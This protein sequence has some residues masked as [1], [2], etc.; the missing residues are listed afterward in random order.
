[1]VDNLSEVGGA[2]LKLGLTSFGG[3]VAHI[4]YFRKEF[5]GRRRWLGDAEFADLVALCQMLPGPAS[6]Q[7]VFC[8]GMQRAGLAGALLASL[9][10]M[11][12]SAVGMV[13]FAYGVAT[14]GHG[15][16]AGW[17][18]GLKLAAVSVVAL[19]VWAMGGSLCPDWSRRLMGLATAAVALFLP[20]TLCQVVAIGACGLVGSLAFRG[21]AP[22][23]SDS[24]RGL[25]R[26]HVWAAASLAVFAG[27]LLLLPVLSRMTGSRPVAVFDGFYRAG[28]LVFGGGHVV[29]PLL[30]SALVPRGWIGD[31]AFLAGY[32]AA[33]AVPGPLFTFAAYLGTV[34]HGEPHAWVGGV[35]ALL[36]IFLP[37]WLLV[38]GAYPFWHLLRGLG[39]AQGALR[40]ANAAVVG[41]LLAALYRP[42]CTE[43]LRDVWD[44]V[45]AAVGI[46]LLSKLKAPP[47]LVVALMAA[48]GQW[49]L[50]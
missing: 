9:C 18:H 47:W 32:G 37:A 3:P 30:R 26:R 16:A 5:V 38:G 29:L 35:L 48:A 50:P 22:A 8:L 2:F 25:G 33:Q 14:L 15:Q 23:P 21:T 12:P 19:A 27:L 6:S 40:G 11:L 17:L 31:N 7:V 20:G 1:V 4:G 49:L 34:I 10:F 24:Q 39:W 36:A 45:A 44:G 43:A 46:V 42:V 41:L 28:S 13:L